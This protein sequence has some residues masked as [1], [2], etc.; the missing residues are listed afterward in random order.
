MGD[1]NKFYLDRYERN[2]LDSVIIP[3]GLN[4][5]SSETPKRITQSSETHI[6][7]I[8]AEDTSKNIVFESNFKADHLSSLLVTQT[9]ITNIDYENLSRLIRKIMI[10]LNTPKLYVISLGTTY[11]AL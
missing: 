11:T 10:P 6:D 7:Y 1:Y 5:C 9:K 8:I 3:Y 4:V 2:N